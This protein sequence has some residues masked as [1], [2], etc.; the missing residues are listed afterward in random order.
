MREYVAGGRRPAVIEPDNFQARWLRREENSHM[1]NRVTVLVVAGQ[2]SF[3]GAI[4]NLGLRVLD[5]LNDFSSDYLHLH[6]VTVRRGIEGKSISQFLEG[7]I[8]KVA[9]DFVLLEPNKHEAPLRRKYALVPKQSRDALILLGEFEI[10]GR[11][12]TTGSFDV[13]PALCQERTAFFPVT[14]VR[15][16]RITS[17]DAPI[18]AGAALINGHKTT[19]LHLARPAVA[20]AT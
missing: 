4:E 12:M 8:P 10:R 6:E 9:V 15:L 7:T 13:L 17:A 14:S 5:V 20:S 11:F 18:S 2:H 16:T 1:A 19:L 3:F